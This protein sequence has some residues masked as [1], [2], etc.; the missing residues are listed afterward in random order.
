M[1]MRLRAV[2][3]PA[4]DTLDRRPREG[5]NPVVYAAKSLALR[6]ASTPARGRRNLILFNQFDRRINS[7][8]ELLLPPKIRHSGEG[9]NP[10]R[11]NID[12]LRRTG[13]QPSLGRR[14]FIARSKQTLALARCFRRFRPESLANASVSH[15]PPM[16]TLA[17][18]AASRPT[19][20][21]LIH[22]RKSESCI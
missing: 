8:R 1:R 13:S 2:I 14:V 21:V 7:R 16:G 19:Q 9:R 22:L 10:V 6:R 3:D 18:R 11:R 20:S 4:S 12:A 15:F 5:G 17:P